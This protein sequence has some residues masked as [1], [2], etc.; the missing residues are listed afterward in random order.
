MNRKQHIYKTKKNWFDILFYVVLIVLILP[1][2]MGYYP[3]LV[4]FP[5]HVTQT[6]S[7]FG[8]LQGDS[9]YNE[10]YEINWFTP[11]IISNLF[12]LLLAFV[13]SPVV[14][15]KIAVTI[16]IISIPLLTQY[17]ARA[18]NKPEE[19]KFITL[20]FLYGFAFHW[21][22][23]PYMTSCFLAAAWIFYYF[24]VNSDVKS[25]VNIVFSFIVMYSHA[26][27]WGVAVFIIIV[28]SVYSKSLKAKMAR[29]YILLPLA[30][31]C[32]WLVYVLT[33]ESSSTESHLILYKSIAYKLV[34]LFS[35]DVLDNDWLLGTIKL[36]FVTIS[37]FLWVKIDRKNN[38]FY[39]I[40]LSIFLLYFILP[41]TLASIAYFSDRILVFMPVFIALSISKVKSQGKFVLAMLIA[42]SLSVASIFSQQNEFDKESSLLIHK[43]AP[44]IKDGSRV[45]IFSDYYDRFEYS[46]QIIPTNKLNWMVHNLTSL[47]TIVPEYT[48]AYVFTQMIRLKGNRKDSDYMAKYRY[49]YPNVDWDMITDFDYVI[50]RDCSMI[51][52]INDEIIRNFK[53]LNRFECWHLYEK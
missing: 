8:I 17:L 11:Y 27:A 53:E 15:N 45:A 32:F 3:G 31:L 37:M 46:Y 49:S 52:S 4:D 14:A 41:N 16:Y 48:F 6:A 39:F 10:Y 5:Q 24:Q 22:F 21:G 9:V 19:V 2:W 43:I 50:I 30:P 13:F 33:Y 38:K 44:M 51:D 35:Y 40:A 7:L 28:D 18:L 1:V 42:T 26:I 23:V 36:F 12:T 25:K 34:S 29:P 20:P 47:K